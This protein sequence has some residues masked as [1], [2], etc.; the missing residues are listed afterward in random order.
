MMK[1]RGV[2]NLSVR[3]RAE[4]FGGLMALETSR[5]SLPMCVLASIRRCASAACASGNDLVNHR[6]DHALLEQRPDVLEQVARD[7]ALLRRRARPQRRA[8]DPA[9]LRIITEKSSSAFAR[10]QERD[11]Q[12]PALDRQQIEVARHVVAADDVED[13]VDAAAV[14]DALAPRR[15]SPR[16][17]S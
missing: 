9:R 14:G 17:G 6:R 7:R 4:R 16:S 12:Q 8:G 11:L 3:L 13:D 10:L 5:M 15:P 2:N 1:K